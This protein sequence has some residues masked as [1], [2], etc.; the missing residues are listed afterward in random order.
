MCHQTVTVLRRKIEVWM[1]SHVRE[2]TDMY[3]HISFWLVHGDYMD[4]YDQQKLYYVE[5]LG[6]LSK[7]G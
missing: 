2:P 7:R 1:S 5:E 6:G 3:L 4:D